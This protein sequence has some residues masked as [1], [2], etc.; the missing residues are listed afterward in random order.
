M[1]KFHS[2]AVAS[3]GVRV[4]V[5]G[6][7]NSWQAPVAMRW[8]A[9]GAEWV[10][11]LLLPPGLYTYKF[12]VDGQWALCNGF[13]TLMDQHGMVNHCIAVGDEAMHPT[14]AEDEDEEREFV[15]E[16]ADET[17]SE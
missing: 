5:W 1:F 17:N 8:D 14:A 11:P 3:T 12:K 10:A 16:A 2:P 4:E 7:F 9:A 6:S 13:P 15:P